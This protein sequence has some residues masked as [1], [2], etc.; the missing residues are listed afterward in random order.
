MKTRKEG[1]HWG[2]LGTWKA[3]RILPNPISPLLGIHHD[4]PAGSSFQRH[5]FC[6]HRRE[7]GLHFSKIEMHVL[8]ELVQ[9]EGL[10]AQVACHELANVRALRHGS[11]VPLCPFGRT[12]AR[13]NDGLW[14]QQ[15]KSHIWPIPVGQHL[16]VVEVLNV[17]LYTPR[18]SNSY[19]HSVCCRPKHED[20]HQ[21]TKTVGN[22][23]NAP[24]GI[25]PAGWRDPK[26]PVGTLGVIPLCYLAG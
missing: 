12:V 1:C 19:R 4:P 23:R 13:E 16:M 17:L 22:N 25:V 26:T 11:L 9:V 5:V 18:Y 2:L 6:R 15:G 10:E 8:Q 7:Q 3:A 14:I 20:V 21:P 24:R